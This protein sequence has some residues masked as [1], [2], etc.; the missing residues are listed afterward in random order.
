MYATGQSIQPINSIFGAGY[1]HE[2]HRD[3]FHPGLLVEDK[4]SRELRF[5]E[6]LKALRQALTIRR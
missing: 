5:A 3:E 4:E 6:I 2:Q 1:V